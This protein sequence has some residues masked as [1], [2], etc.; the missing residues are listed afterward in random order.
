MNGNVVLAVLWIAVALIPIA[1]MILSY[2]GIEP[3]WLVAIA[4]D[5]VG[6]AWGTGATALGVVAVIGHGSWFALA[7]VTL[8]AFLLHIVISQVRLRRTRCRDVG[9][10]DA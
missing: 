3:D 10:T 9:A 8:G 2:C 1:V 4:T 6:L 7:W 5:R